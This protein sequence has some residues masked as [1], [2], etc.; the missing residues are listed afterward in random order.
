MTDIATVVGCIYSE[1]SYNQLGFLEQIKKCTRGF[2]VKEVQQYEDILLVRIDNEELKA[3][4][5][6]VEIQLKDFETVENKE[7]K[8]VCAHGRFADAV[9]TVNGPGNT[10]QRIENF[11]TPKF[12]KNRHCARHTFKA[13]TNPSAIS[14]NHSL[15]Q[16]ISHS[17]RTTRKRTSSKKT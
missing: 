8:A 17:S 14:R 6:T 5:V 3:F 7:E 12:G 9:G 4:W 16:E 15:L 11:E 10:N 1:R 2:I 13:F